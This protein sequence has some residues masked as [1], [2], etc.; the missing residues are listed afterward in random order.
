MPQNTDHAGVMWHGSYVAW[1]EE[2]RIDALSQAGLS[3]KDLSNSGYELPVVNLQINYL[4]PLLHGDIA[5]LKSWV[6]PRNGVRIPWRTIF[7]KGDEI[8][9]AEAFVELV[10][11]KSYTV[12]RSL[13]RKI[14][15]QLEIPFLNLIKGPSCS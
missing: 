8:I 5:I 11:V 7:T 9:L 2:S 4:R 15:E 10:L 6:S 3:Y 14:P 13:I 1:L 12:D